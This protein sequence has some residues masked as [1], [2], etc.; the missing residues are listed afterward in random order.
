MAVRLTHA[1][2][3]RSRAELPVSGDRSPI[4][5]FEEFRWSSVLGVLADGSWLNPNDAESNEGLVR[6]VLLRE[7]AATAR[8][9]G[10]KN[11]AFSSHLGAAAAWEAP[12]S[13]P[14]PFDVTEAGSG[15]D[16]HNPSVF[17][18]PPGL[19]DALCLSASATCVAMC[20]RNAPHHARLSLKLLDSH[21]NSMP[22]IGEE[23]VRTYQMAC[24]AGSV[25]EM[26][27][28]GTLGEQ[29]L[30]VIL[31]PTAPASTTTA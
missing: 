6:A 20:S 26:P 13:A 31:T 27:I 10:L 1:C 8:F 30:P 2:A 4:R 21:D 25:E 3:T 16:G 28:R 15:G 23:K 12:A 18:G 9:S 5:L 24:S 29:R 17:P 11:F 19:R 14:R 22:I 7:Q